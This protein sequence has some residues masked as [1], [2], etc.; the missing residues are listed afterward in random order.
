MSDVVFITGNQRKVDYLQMWLGLPVKHHKLDL[1]ELQSLDPRTV[2]EHKAR[3]AYGILQEPVLIE[4]VAL[5]FTAMGRLPGTFVKH[6]L[7]EIGNE[8]LCKIADNLAHRKAVAVVTYAYC[9]GR[10]VHFFDARVH[11]TVAPEPRGDKGMGWD[12]SFIPDGDTRT[13]AEMTDDEK[14]PYSARAAATKKLRA[15][16]D[17]QG[18]NRGAPSG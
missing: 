5:T 3:Q 2:A 15:F 16:L 6:F 10:D 14:K 7:E 17:S 9:D 4:D 1:D 12:P 11:G 8:G 18:N 13:F